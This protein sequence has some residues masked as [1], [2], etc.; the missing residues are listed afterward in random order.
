MFWYRNKTKDLFCFLKH[1]YM[2]NNKTFLNMEDVIYKFQ[3]TNFYK[4][5]L[6]F[7]FSKALPFRIKVAIPFFCF[8]KCFKKS[9]CLYG[10]SFQCIFVFFNFYKKKIEFHFCFKRKSFQFTNVF[11]LEKNYFYKMFLINKEVF[12]FN[13]KFPQPKNIQFHHKNIFHTFKKV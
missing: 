11:T 10:K 12:Q 7:Y 9:L 6:C 13:I 2:G 5:V 4:T 3:N 1:N 8:T